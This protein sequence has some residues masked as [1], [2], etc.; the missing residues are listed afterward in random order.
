MH[1]VSGAHYAHVTHTQLT[2]DIVSIILVHKIANAVQSAISAIA[3]FLVHGL[4]ESTKI[5]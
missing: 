3:G 4:N 2:C 1:Y 5:E